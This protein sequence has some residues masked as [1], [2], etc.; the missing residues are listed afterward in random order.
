MNTGRLLEEMGDDVIYFTSYNENNLDDYGKVYIA[1][2]K[3]DVK[4]FK[5]LNNVI[6]FYYSQ[7]SYENLLEVIKSEMP[8]IAHLHIFY[9]NLSSSILRALNKCN[10]PVVMS[11]HEYR[12]L[13]PVSIM[14]TRD[15]VVCERCGGGKYYNAIRRRCNRG[16]YIYSA[17]SSSECFFRDS[18]FDY[19]KLVDHFIMVSH[20]IQRKHLCYYPDLSVKSTVLYNFFDP[21]KKSDKLP[22]LY[23]VIYYGR[24]SREK[25]VMTFLKAIKNFKEL[26]FAIIGR[27]P[28]QKEVTDYIVRHNMS[29]V[30]IIGYMS[31]EKLYDIVRSSKYV[32][33][34]SEW[35][36]NNPMTVIESLSM[37]IP[38]IGARIG[39]IP[40]LIN[41][42]H[43][44]L[45]NPGDDSDLKEAIR[46]AI[47]LSDQEYYRMSINAIK[48]SKINFD[49]VSH[50]KRLI[51]IYKKAIAK[52]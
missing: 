3:F 21:P 12:M 9:G 33:V 26:R 45:F 15:G 48:Y 25:G 52:P 34:P 49:K 31:G 43:G 20:F 41:D 8:D 50:Y 1:N 32:V 16:S 22:K 28:E 19:K 27:G 30:K 24:L 36:E 35:Y 46:R 18:F 38:V 44:Y 39:G 47:S 14:L 13:C 37:G 4:G 17:I 6:G 10:I 2:S 11:V 7:A 29:N 5:S 23:D 40:E 51:D 42:N